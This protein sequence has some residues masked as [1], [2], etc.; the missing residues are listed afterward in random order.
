MISPIRTNSAAPSSRHPGRTELENST[1]FCIRNGKM[2]ENLMGNRTA[3]GCTNEAVEQ[4]QRDG[5]SRRG[6]GQTVANELGTSLHFT[7]FYKIKP[8]HLKPF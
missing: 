3:K 8:V 1:A 2:N 7:L 6:Y 4:K 5:G